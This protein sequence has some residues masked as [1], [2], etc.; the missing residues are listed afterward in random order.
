MINA[1]FCQRLPEVD[2]ICDLVNQAIFKGEDVAFYTTEDQEGVDFDDYEIIEYQGEC[3][4]VMNT[5]DIF[6]KNSEAIQQDFDY[7]TADRV[8]QPIPASVL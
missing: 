3:I 4:T 1:S 8:S 5:W 2:M 6:S 7:I